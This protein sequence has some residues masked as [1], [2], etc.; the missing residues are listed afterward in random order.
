MPQK[1]ILFY[2]FECHIDTG[3]NAPVISII[4]TTVTDGELKKIYQNGY[5]SYATYPMVCTFYRQDSVTYT[6]T[7]ENPLV[8]VLET[9]DE[10]G[11]IVTIVR[12]LKSNN[13]IVRLP[14]ASYTRV[15]FK[16]TNKDGEIFE[17]TLKLSSE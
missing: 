12:N 15:Q 7:M 13:F 2:Q 6:V 3:T 8:Q 14:Y 9:Q 10:G 16:I 5:S 11:K 4:K 1:Q 17:Q